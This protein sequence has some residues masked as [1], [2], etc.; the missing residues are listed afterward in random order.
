MSLLYETD[1]FT[2][3]TADIPLVSREEGGHILILPK[4]KVTDRTKLT[5]QLAT[6]YMKLSMV[7]GEAMKAGLAKR[8]ID[9]GIIN[10]QD[11]GNWTIFKPGGPFLHMNIFGRATN[12]IIQK[13][14]DAVQLPRKNTG[15]YNSF[16][17]FDAED[18]K[19]IKKEIE[20]QMNTEKYKSF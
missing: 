18:R 16:K 8:G 11:M 12:A 5:P 9:I 13:Y 3:E 14:G 20:R 1:N 17:P 15:F 2:I 6:E 19:E 7:V 10:Y 4:V